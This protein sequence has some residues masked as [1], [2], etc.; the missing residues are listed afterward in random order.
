MTR[1]R[2][3]KRYRGSTAVKALRIAKRIQRTYKPETKYLEVI[4]GTQ[5]RN[6]WTEVATMP[7]GDGDGERIGLRCRL[8]RLIFDMR[9]Q[10]PDN[11]LDDSLLIRV[12][13]IKIQK[14]I[15]PVTSDILNPSGATNDRVRAWFTLQHERP[16]PFT[17]LYERKFMMRPHWIDA[18]TTRY[19]FTFIRKTIKLDFEKMFD[20][21]L[22]T[23]GL[24]NRVYTWW[25]CDSAAVPV[26]NKY[27]RLEYTDV[28]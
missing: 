15:A 12:L 18:A 24:K 22:G 5:L 7:Q 2:S 21:P 19:D 17:V 14:N 8:K 9:F 23:D 20:G 3:R 4:K 28:G 1:V 13:V 11:V 6:V 10:I 27:Q 26:F 16:H 25:E